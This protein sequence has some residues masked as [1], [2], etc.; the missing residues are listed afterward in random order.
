MPTITRKMLK[1]KM[2]QQQQR[3]RLKCGG[4]DNNDNNDNN[5]DNNDADNHE[6]GHEYHGYPSASLVPSLN[7]GQKK[8]V[9][10]PIFKMS[11]KS[12]ITTSLSLPHLRCLCVAYGLKKTGTKPILIERALT[13]CTRQCAV[14]ALQRV[15]RG[16]RARI[17]VHKFMKNPIYRRSARAVNETDVYTMD[18]FTEV[19]HYQLFRFNDE[20]DG[21]IYQFNMASFFKLLKTAI[22]AKD[23]A[24]V[25]ALRTIRVCSDWTADS[26]TLPTLLNP[27]NRVPISNNVV[28]TFFTKM[29]Y[30][31]MLRHPVCI[32]FKEEALTP[33]QLVEGQILELFQDIN[34]LGNY[35]DSNW[36]SALKH[37]QHI[38]FIQELYDIWS[39]RAELSMQTKC[40]I[41]PPTGCLF[42]N[43]NGVF[44]NPNSVAIMNEIRTAPFNVVREINL[45][46]IDRLIRSGLT[47]DDRKL[48]AFYVL[49][50]LTLVSI[51]ARDALPWLY[52]SVVGSPTVEQQ[53]QQ[54]QQQHQQQQHQQQHQQQQQQQQQQELSDIYY[55]NYNNP[56]YY[57][58]ADPISPPVAAVALNYNI[59]NNNNN[60]NNIIGNGGLT[61]LDI[62]NLLQFAIMG[63]VLNQNSPSN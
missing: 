20:S 61:Q 45:S 31:R 41:C 52:H 46:V 24:K 49:S 18:E 4:G 7:R 35:A 53:Q 25:V 59:I 23:W 30:S 21:M 50:A 34:A 54:H 47:E 9:E 36:L 56:Y 26:D 2:Q 32:E 11:E 37:P 43:L 28:Q 27:Y 63:S 60:N 13:H 51:G 10:M 57:T 3:R 48:G 15:M 42:A 39:Y 22:V 58:Y 38:R 14:T 5:N 12:K 55:N 29:A 6:D 33:V 40:Q 17:Y 19:S 62:N 8:T 44:A 16:Y 1:T